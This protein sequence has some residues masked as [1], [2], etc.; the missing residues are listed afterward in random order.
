MGIKEK[1]ISW[2]KAGSNSEWSTMEIGPNFTASNLSYAASKFDNGSFANAN[3]E[4]ASANDSGVFF[5]PS[6]CIISIWIETDDSV[7]NGVRNTFKNAIL[8]SWGDAG[9]TNYI[10]FKSFTTGLGLFVVHSTGGTINY[11]SNSS[12]LTFSANTL[13]KLDIVIDKDGIN[14]GSEYVRFYL[15]KNKIYGSTVVFPDFSTATPSQFRYLVNFF[16]RLDNWE[17]GL[18]NPKIYT[19]TNIND[20][21]INEVIE[22]DF[23]NE[24]FP[25]VTDTLPQV[26]NIKEEFPE[27]ILLLGKDF[28]KE[29]WINSFPVLEYERTFGEDQ[30]TL[31]EISIELDNS[32]NSFSVDN[33]KS[34]FYGRNYI[35]EIVEMIEGNLI[36]FKG[37]IIN[38]KENDRTWK[39]ILKGRSFLNK[40]RYNRVI[41][42]SGGTW[43]TP[44]TAAKKIF[45]DL[46]IKNLNNTSFVNAENYYNSN[47]VLIKVN[48]TFDDE[49]NLFEVM[50]EIAAHSA[51]DIYE[52]NGLVYFQNY[53]ENSP[54]SKK[55][56]EANDLKAAPILEMDEK[57]IINQYLIEYDGGGSVEDTIETG[58]N[59]RKVF[60]TRYSERLTGAGI[61]TFKDATAADFIGQNTIKMTHYDLSKL[62]KGR[63]SINIV[64]DYNNSTWID[65]RSFFKLN[66]PSKNWNEKLFEVFKIRR[67]KENGNIEIKAYERAN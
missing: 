44:A 32:E 14:G 20:T 36:L 15:N 10:H 3:L 38:L 62:A 31:P 47:N 22:N 30:L 39:T 8:L 66:Y 13:Q 48:V 42:S 50:D 59:S 26:V 6:K 55:I 34:L 40:D 46:G 25:F 18:D 11:I 63:R 28:I 33:P 16:N 19:D 67:D 56:I 57:N 5:N 23:V 37:A 24:G 35:N 60:G 61:I 64:I 43:E 2:G 4:E 29:G 52:F 45:D 21:F 27:K 51:A 9:A 54:G 49:M 41:Y 58:L 17:G 53:T 65:L 1:C 12:A 7:S